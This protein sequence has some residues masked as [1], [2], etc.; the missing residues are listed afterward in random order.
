MWRKT[1]AAFAA[2]TVSLL[3]GTCFADGDA[4]LPEYKP[5]SGVSGKAQRSRATADTC[6]SLKLRRSRS[7][8]NSSSTGERGELNA[9]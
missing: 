3:G 8:R 9:H 6:H 1:V 7:G 5:V 4:D 2:T